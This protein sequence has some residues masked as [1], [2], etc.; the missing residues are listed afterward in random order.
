[1]E[2]KNTCFGFRG[3]VE[4]CWVLSPLVVLLLLRGRIYTL[5]A[6]VIK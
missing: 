1:M 6:E 2:N 3:K 5:K 4:N